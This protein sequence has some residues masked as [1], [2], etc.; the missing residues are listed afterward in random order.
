MLIGILNGKEV[1]SFISTLDENHHAAMRRAIGGAFSPKGTLD[2]EEA[3]DKTI[4]ELLDMLSQKTSCDLSSVIAYYAVDAASRFSFGS[5]VGCL[6]AE[7]DVGG[8]IKLFRDRF[9]H[10]GRWSSFPW[11]ER[12]V[13]RNPIALRVSRPSAKITAAAVSRLEFHMAKDED[14]GSSSRPTDLISKFV[15]SSEVHPQL[16]DRTGIIS[17]LMSV[18]SAGGDTIATTII[19]T[20]HYLLRNPETLAKLEGEL[21]DADIDT[22]VP[23]YHQVSKLPYLHAVIRESMRLFSLLNWPLERRVPCGGVTIAGVTFPEG[24]SVGCNVSA[25]HMNAEFFGDDVD[26]F[27]PERWLEAGQED[28]R[29]MEAAHMGFS[30]GRRV[31]I[32]QHIA[33]MQM[34]KVIPTLVANFKVSESR[35]PRPRSS[36]DTMLTVPD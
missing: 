32:G 4:A 7:A 8:T 3:I 34:K 33:V 16:L 23:R 15:E 24:V 13:H 35:P 36:V 26:L 29:R 10:W 31:C 9:D 12:V 28:L 5:P 25:L 1:P 19:A 11:L 20:M 14:G 18:I 6:A 17:T 21:S 22:P 2:Y 27:R 30:K